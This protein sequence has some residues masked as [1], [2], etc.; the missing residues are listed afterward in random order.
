M[1]ETIVYTRDQAGLPYSKGLMAQSLSASGLSPERSYELARLVEQRLDERPER[2]IGAA[3][4]RDLVEEVVLEE[5]GSDAVR[6][7]HEW[8]R[9]D[10]LDRPLIVMLS[11]TTGVGKSTLATMLA[12]RL[13]ITRVIATDVIRQVLRAF[14]SRE[15]MPT[16]HYSAFEAGQAAD[17]SVESGEDRDLVGF[18]RQAES[19]GTAVEAIVE[20]ACMERTPM[21][22]EG[23][24]LV[25]G[26]IRGELLQR[27]IAVEALLVVEDEDRHRSHFA[28]R[29][30]HRP[31]ERY[32]NRF[33]QIR[34][35]QDHLA[36]RAREEGVAVI[37]N[38]SVDRALPRLMDLVLDSVG[39]LSSS[40]AG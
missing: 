38:T 14:F 10:R 24:H 9:L 1:P 21:V 33:E 3:E 31:A 28:M 23:I 30:G 12:G 15:F 27:C 2:R 25:P 7:F 37:D 40:E 13:G 16:V 34:K 35:L 4:L 18:T 19:V 36:V 11:G 22:L 29:G 32:L 17:L 8:Q 26:T 20:R 39:R 5:E 6:R